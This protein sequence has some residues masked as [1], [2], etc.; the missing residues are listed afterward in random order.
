ME[1]GGEEGG[2]ESEGWGEERV[3]SSGLG[4]Q[5]GEK[6]ESDDASREEEGGKTDPEV[7]YAV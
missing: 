5:G 6:E 3:P 2:V 7:V 4:G 1:E